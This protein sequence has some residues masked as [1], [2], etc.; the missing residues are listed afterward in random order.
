[1]KLKEPISKSETK[2]VTEV[3]HYEIPGF[4]LER[5]VMKETVTYRDNN[6]PVKWYELIDLTPKKHYYPSFVE[7]R[8][9]EEIKTKNPFDTRVSK[10]IGY[11]SAKVYSSD[12]SNID[13][14]WEIIL[15]SVSDNTIMDKNDVPIMYAKWYD[16][17]GTPF[18]SRVIKL[19]ENFLEFLRNHPWVVNKDSLEIEEIPYYN[20]GSGDETFVSVQL[21]P[22]LETYL[23]M[24]EYTKNYGKYTRIHEVITSSI[25]SYNKDAKD[26]F[27]IRPFLK[28]NESN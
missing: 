15:V 18:S 10:D 9:F 11:I 3:F 1:M 25:C 20:N 13:P 21:L 2:I 23:E 16:Y 4:N 8:F 27:G 5:F 19:D 12:P 26:Y 24:K 28:K 6:E 17:I 22:D 14:E 7:K